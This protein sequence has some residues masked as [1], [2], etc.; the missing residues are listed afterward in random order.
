VVV[1][2]V[3]LSCSCC[4]FEL[5]LLLIK[6]PDQAIASTPSALRSPRGGLELIL[7]A[8]VLL[9][10]LVSVLLQQARLFAFLRRDMMLLLIPCCCVL[11]ISVAS[12]IALVRV[13]SQLLQPHQSS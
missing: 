2:Y 5:I 11:G 12:G 10:L 3:A 4:F 8:V 7:Y 9:L 1:N 13:H 6:L